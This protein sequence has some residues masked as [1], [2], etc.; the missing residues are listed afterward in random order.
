MGAG[1]WGH[2]HAATHHMSRWKL[3]VSTSLNSLQGTRGCCYS[4][5]TPVVNPHPQ[6]RALIMP[7]IPPESSAKGW[8]VDYRMNVSF[9]TGLRVW[10][11]T[12]VRWI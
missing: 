12:W 9:H 10:F 11:M 8:G 6:P 1:S 7:S 4:S 5:N 2:W 3:A